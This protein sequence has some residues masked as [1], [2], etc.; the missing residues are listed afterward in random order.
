MGLSA[1]ATTSIVVLAFLL[2]LAALI[3][4]LAADRALASA[5]RD[6]QS[7]AQLAATLDDTPEA[8]RSLQVR[9]PEDASIQLA[10]GEVIG[11]ELP[12]GLDLIQAAN[13]GA[14]SRQAVDGGQAVVVPVLK[15]DSAWIV[16]VSVPTAVLMENVVA[17]WL[18]LATLGLALIAVAALVADR[19]GRSIVRPIQNLVAATERL[20][21][22]ELDA[23]VTPSGPTELVQVGA[24]FNQLSQ[25]VAQLLAGE[26]ESIADLSHRLRTPLTA[27]KLDVEAL[28]GNVD[29]SRLQQDID[30]LERTVSHLI[31]EARRPIREAAGAVTDL[32]TVVAARAKY[33]GSLAEDQRREWQLQLPDNPCRVA[34]R[35]TDFVAAV[36]AL[37]G[38][39][40]A[41]T[42]IGT[43]YVIEL[44]A[45]ETRAIL[46]ISDQ[47]P[48]LVDHGLLERGRSSGESTGLGI[49][50]VRNT[51][52]AAGGS[53]EWI[54]VPPGGTKVQISLPLI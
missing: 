49:D 44:S 38:N 10:P 47:G 19:L 46:T 12:H 54:S 42:P 20:G 8:V 24:A 51:A 16:V 23:S 9:L 34:G 1:V 28:E 37:I 41:H 11:A 18:V 36:D 22:G 30:E 7:V 21:A 40:F 4:D 25:R 50:I 45:D 2:P 15:D 32:T 5:E 3:R 48:G 31:N 26:R 17:S 29:V 43:P 52:W 33:W 53:A 6:A 14:A 39:I 27:L 13:L 35:D